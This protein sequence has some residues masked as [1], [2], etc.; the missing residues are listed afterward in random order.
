M[1]SLVLSLS[2]RKRPQNLASVAEDMA[3]LVM[4]EIVW[5]VLLLGGVSLCSL[6]EALGLVGFIYRNKCPP[7]RLRALASDR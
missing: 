1:H 2:L 6:G 5:T 7:T 3:F 4:V